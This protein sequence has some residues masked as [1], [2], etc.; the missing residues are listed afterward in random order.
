MSNSV[1]ATVM[2]ELLK[3]NE[4]AIGEGPE[5]YRAFSCCAVRLEGRASTSESRINIDSR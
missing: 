4:E 2:N 5:D 1:R 3:S